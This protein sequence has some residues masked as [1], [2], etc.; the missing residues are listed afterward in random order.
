ML[1]VVIVDNCCW[2]G[3]ECSFAFVCFDSLRG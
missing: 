1:A 2:N 3:C